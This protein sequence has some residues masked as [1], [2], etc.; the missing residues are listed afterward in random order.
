MHYPLRKIFGLRRIFDNVYLHSS[1]IIQHSINSH[2]NFYSA[3]WAV[4]TNPLSLLNGGI[5]IFCNN[6]PIYN[7]NSTFLD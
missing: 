1:E 4:F 7:P 2:F 3:F 6:F 5:V